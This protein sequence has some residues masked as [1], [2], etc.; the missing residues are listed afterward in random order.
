[1]ISADPSLVLAE[2]ADE[3]ASA[4]G[5]C[6]ASIVVR[7]G[8]RDDLL[9]ATHP[10]LSELAELE[11]RLGDG[12]G[13]HAAETGEPVVVSDTLN[14]VRWPAFSRLALRHGVRACLA[15]GARGPAGSV[16]ITVHG[17]VPRRLEAA[18]GPLVTLFCRHAGLL[19]AY[20][21]IYERERRAHAELR[22][23][24]ATRWPIE[25]A[26]GMIM[27]ALGCDADEAFQELRRVSQNSHLKLRDV[28]QSIISRQ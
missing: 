1:M 22:E 14:D 20:A 23:A 27:Q 8:G 26:K 19:L 15:A 25:Q 10:D 16:A 28:A 24:L 3:A 2:L 9:V 12:P 5:A 17:L 6:G 11:Q 4:A 7:G 21:E 13:W 18:Q